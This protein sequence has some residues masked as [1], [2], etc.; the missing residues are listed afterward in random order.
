LENKYSYN[1]ILNEI[2]QAPSTKRP[3]HLSKA[4]SKPSITQQLVDTNKCDFKIMIENHHFILKKYFIPSID[5]LD[6]IKRDVN[7]T[8]ISCLEH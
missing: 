2:F 4:N 3:E 6:F 1:I 8:A 5:D 7:F